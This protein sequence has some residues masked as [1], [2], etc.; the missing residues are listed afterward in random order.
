[1]KRKVVIEGSESLNIKNITFS[2]EVI[3]HEGAQYAAL[4]ERQYARLRK[5]FCGK[6]GCPID[7]W[8]TAHP[9]SPAG[10][11]WIRLT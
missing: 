8:P 1:V 9:D 11:Y 5:R 4:D 6:D 2:A 10:E 7:S 3:D